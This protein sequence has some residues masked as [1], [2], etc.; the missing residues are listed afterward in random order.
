MIYPLLHCLPCTNVASQLLLFYPF[1]VFKNI[2][3]VLLLKHLFW[4]GFS[5]VF[6]A[7]WT[8]SLI[9]Q[10]CRFYFFSYLYESIFCPFFKCCRK[11]KHE[12][13]W[14]SPEGSYTTFL[15]P[16]KYFSPCFILIQST[17]S[18]RHLFAFLQPYGLKTWKVNFLQLRDSRIC[19]LT[20]WRFLTTQRAQ[21]SQR[22]L[23]FFPWKELFLWRDAVF[24]LESAC[25]CCNASVV[26]QNFE[27]E[28]MVA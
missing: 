16:K 26:P 12:Q 2:Y 15:M 17:H 7:E 6:S 18:S 4:P 8:R 1:V 23:Y 19:Y 13:Q 22:P 3:P 10:L 21:Y 24:F 27:K 9:L 11:C 25:D 28:S 14:A 20:W 5:F